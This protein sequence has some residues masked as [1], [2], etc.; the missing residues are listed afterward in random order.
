MKLSVQQ[1][2]QILTVNNRDD[3]YIY[4]DCPVCNEPEFFLLIKENNQP[5]GCSRANKCGWRGNIYTLLKLLGKTRDFLSER[6]VDAFEK[7]ENNLF[8]EEKIELTFDLPELRP[9]VLWQRTYKDEYLDSRGFT[10]E[11]YHKFEVG[12]SKIKKD[13]ITFLVRQEGKLVGYISRS[14]KSKEWIDEYNIKQKE[15]K[16]ANYLRYDNSVSDF[17]KMVFGLDEIIPG[18]TKDVI[19]VEGIFSKTK[20]DSNLMLDSL[21]EIKC[22]STFGSKL[23][24]HQIELLKQRRIETLWFWFEA[25]VLEKIKPI[26][27]NAAIHFDVKV[28]FLNG[29]DP[30][31]I[32]SDGA[33]KLLDEGK[34]FLD[35]NTSFIKSNLRI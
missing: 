18:K 8:K 31:D 30:N 15:S 14:T 5:C 33:M 19:L 20:T 13:Y 10:E 35:F 28:N 29:F 16:G 9:P 25:D 7:L 1:I 26:V 3:K 11:Q 6:E 17:S 2:E 4:A 34:N 27:A 21:D 24:D 12:R 23:S 22:V 32:D